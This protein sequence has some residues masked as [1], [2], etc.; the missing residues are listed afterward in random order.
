VVTG[1]AGFI[2]SHLSAAL[3]DRGARVRVVDD[4]RTGRREWVP[5]GA[6]FLQ[7][8]VVEAAAEAVRD[9]GLVF[10]LAAV[11]SVP[12]SVE[13]PLESHRTTARS[14][15]EV[16]AAAEKAGV[17]RVVF[18][19]SSAVYGDTPDLPKRE[20]T[21]AR[22]L[23]PYAA[24]KLAGELYAVSWAAHT[25]LETVS[26]R[27]FNV[28]GPRQSPDSPYAPVIPKFIECLRAGRPMP[29]Y[30]DGRQTR[31]FVYV[32]DVVR[33][34]LAAAEAPGISG[35]VYN[36]ADGR[37]RAILDV[38]RAVASVLGVEPRF[39]FLP[40]RRGDARESWADVTAMRRD[41]GAESTPFE[42]GLR[43]TGE[44]FAR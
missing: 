42:E 20:D 8:D 5:D 33:R 29:V 36:V 11:P 38:G 31:D 13:N 26:L 34:L 3:R 23:S 30:G 43:R 22:P 27:F 18:A 16:L 4:L 21:P 2:G 28:F 37:P 14:T 40:P 17:R 35:R 44:G 12:W 10:H 25:R 24:A 9:A 15:L 32:E 6:E 19:S 39:E 7:A 1:G 41:L